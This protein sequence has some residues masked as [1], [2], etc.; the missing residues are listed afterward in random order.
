MNILI[1]GGTGFI[2]RPLTRTLLA[3]H[4]VTVWCRDPGRVVEGARAITSLD[5]YGEGTPDAV[6]NLAGENIAARRWS[7]ARKAVLRASRIDTTT[8]LGQWLAARDAA[9][10]VLVSG[11][12]IGV[13]GLGAGDDPVTESDSGDASFSST[14]CR[15]W[16]QAAE[17]ACPEGTRL[18]LLRTGIVLGDGG[19][20]AKMLPPFRLGLGGVI[21]SG[22]HWMPWIHIDDIIALIVAL[23]SDE[24]ASGP[25][26]AVAP[27]PVSNRDFTKA[28]GTV[29]KRPTV[30]PMPGPV[31]K[32][33]F[34][35]MGVELLLHGRRVL[36]ASATALGFRF[37]FTTLESAL[38]D[39]L[40]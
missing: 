22:S 4:T 40:G 35:E 3:D 5:D 17:Q 31:V 38:R 16:E 37:R 15:D 33:L 28:L 6:I 27:T 7:D 23:L 10:R 8:A 18:C 14:L 24:R 19:A 11:S 25:I 29:L 20:L 36:P 39:L 26:N 21:G 1:T 32:T 9:P 12:A 13:Y 2:G 30:F 34:G